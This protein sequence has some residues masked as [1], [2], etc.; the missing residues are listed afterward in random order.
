[1]GFFGVNFWS[2]EFF[3]GFAGSPRDFFGSWFLAPFDHACHL[4]SRVPP[5]GA[6]LSCL[7]R[8]LYQ[9][10]IILAC[11]CKCRPWT[12][13]AKKQVPTEPE[14]S[15]GAHRHSI[16]AAILWYQLLVSWYDWLKCWMMIDFF[17]ISIWQVFVKY[18]WHLRQLSSWENVHL[19]FSFH[20]WPLNLSLFHKWFWRVVHALFWGGVWLWYSNFFRGYTHGFGTLCCYLHVA[21]QSLTPPSCACKFF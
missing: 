5:T 9:A 6:V 2:R 18:G 17:E 16:D 4:K 19:P 12:L 15:K 3:G 7:C 1:M 13:L 11:T 10:M 8:N 21:L 14:W 20:F